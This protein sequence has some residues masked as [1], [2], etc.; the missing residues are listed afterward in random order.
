MDIVTTMQRVERHI[1]DRHDPRWSAIDAACFLSKNLYNAANY[2]VR[3][4]Y[5]FNQRYIPYA[6]LDK[7][8]KHNPDYCALP[9]KVSQWVLKQVDHDWQA[10]FAAQAAWQAQ[11]ETF[12]SRPHLP[13]YKP[14]TTG[15][16]LLTYTSQAV[17]RTALKQGFIQPSQLAITVKTQQTA[18]DQ[19][20]IVPRP[21]HYV[22]EVVYTVVPQPA[23]VDPDRVLSADLG[24]DTLAALTS[25]QPGFVPLLV[26]GRPLKSLNCWYNKPAAIGSA[27]RTVHLPSHSPLDAKPQSAH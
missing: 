13:G 6:Q 11:P 27:C 2:I 16:N 19:V 4:T 26:N 7:L 23:N 15:R 3:Q 14:K 1:I 8:M 24:V 22:V 12:Q 17:S 5:L 18:L 20:R 9:R 21:H 10:F 25:N